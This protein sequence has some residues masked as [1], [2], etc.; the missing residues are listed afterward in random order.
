MAE[1]ARPDLEALLIA[2]RTVREHLDDFAASAGDHL[3]PGT[4]CS[5]AL[6]HRGHDRLA[7]SSGP[8]PASCD[9]AE[10]A[11]DEGPCLTAMDQLQVVLVP[12]VGQEVRWSAWLA[13]TTRVGFRS[14]A[15]VPAH[16]ADGAEVALNMYSDRVDPWSADALARADTYAQNV[17]R[18]VGLCLQVAD[19]TDQVRDLEQAVATRDV[20]NQAVG[21]V[22]ATNGCTAAEALAVLRSASMNRD[23]DMVEVASALVQGVTGHEPGS[24]DDPGDG[25]PPDGA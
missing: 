7:A 1:D 21:V 18:T 8:D 4:Q 15:A 20:I 3:A 17:A 5:I 2:S 6:R 13:Q 12:D 9:E 10:I 25:P 23:V 16:V 24:V 22:M 19:L 14:S 11:A